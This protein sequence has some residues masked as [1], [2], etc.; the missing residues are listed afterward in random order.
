MDS[1]AISCYQLSFGKSFLVGKTVGPWG[2]A[3]FP[4]TIP[5]PLKLTRYVT[6]K[7]SDCVSVSNIC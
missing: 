4:P 7:T 3:T 1:N 5:N 2:Y 6:K